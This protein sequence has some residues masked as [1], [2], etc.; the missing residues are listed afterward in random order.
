MKKWGIRQS[1]ETENLMTSVERLIEYVHLDEEDNGGE[2][3]KQWPT[4]GK[5]E[6]QNVHFSYDNKDRIYLLFLKC[7]KKCFFTIFRW[8]HNFNNKI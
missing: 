6:F 5:L 2:I 1:T 3:P 8:C 7:L 4:N